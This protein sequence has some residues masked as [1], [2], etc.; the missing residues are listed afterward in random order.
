M[1]VYTKYSPTEATVVKAMEGIPNSFQKTV[2]TTAASK[3]V[4]MS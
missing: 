1:T 2:L 4:G 3:K